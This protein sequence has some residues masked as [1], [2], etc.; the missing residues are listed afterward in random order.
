M[1]QTDY[2]SNALGDLMG[3]G[4]VQAGAGAPTYSEADF[5]KYL[6]G[7]MTLGELRGLTREDAYAIA[8]IGHAQM[9]EG[10]L[11]VARTIFE[12][13]LAANPKDPY[14][15]LL[16]AAVLGRQGHDANA[17]DAYSLAL[18]LD[19]EN[20]E[21]LANRAEL[22]LKNGVLDMAIADLKKIVEIDPEA[23][24]AYGV[25]ARA[26][27]KAAKTVVDVVQEHADE[28]KQAMNKK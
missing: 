4:A 1:T 11:D 28:I 25:R 12:G 2:S 16:E 8:A 7:E 19:G 24:T 26:L 13:L 21:A 6:A 14:F 22:L 5:E 3:D 9:L 17:V 18:E 10:K 15:W 23:K 20:L 27:A